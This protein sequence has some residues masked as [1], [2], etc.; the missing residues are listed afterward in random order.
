MKKKTLKFGL[1]VLIL[2][3]VGGLL[4]GLCLSWSS[5]EPEGSTPPEA[6]LLVR[7]YTDNG[8]LEGS[9]TVLDGTYVLTTAH[10]IGEN[11]VRIYIGTS[12]GKHY[13]SHLVAQN[14]DLD[15]ALLRIG[16]DRRDFPSA[17]LGNSRRLQIGQAVSASE[18]S[19][20]ITALSKSLSAGKL[21]IRRDFD[22][23]LEFDAPVPA[24][25]SGS[26]LL[27]ERGHV[28]GLI[29]ARSLEDEKLSYALPINSVKKFLK[30]SIEIR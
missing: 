16:S 11:I 30:E 12:D 22:D 6:V 8:I 3:F 18:G 23:L 9:G 24:G 2:I 10:T 13:S 27:D 26:P 4:A 1:P 20:H 15:L 19:G 7:S 5:V 17:V 28:I 25:A 14:A 21:L 29:L